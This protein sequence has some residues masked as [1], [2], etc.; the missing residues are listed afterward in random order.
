MGPRGFKDMDKRHYHI[1]DVADV[2]EWF[3]Y[4]ASR[5][6]QA[7]K[8]IKSLR[9]SL[10]TQKSMVKAYERKEKLASERG[11]AM[12]QDPI[13]A[14]APGTLESIE[15]KSAAAQ[16]ASILSELQEVLDSERD[17]K[18]AEET[19]KATSED[20]DVDTG[21]YSVF[22]VKDSPRFKKGN[23]LVKTLDVPEAIRE[24]LVKDKVGGES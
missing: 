24:K 11:L 16:D 18:Q 3:T 2:I 1:K 8:V 5:D 10:N 23:V 9:N 7:L 14:G 22:F 21:E 13:P 4:R 20:G 17:Q 19:E 6:E 15:H 12:S